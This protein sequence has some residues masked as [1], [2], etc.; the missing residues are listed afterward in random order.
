MPTLFSTWASCDGIDLL[1]ACG[2][3]ATVPATCPLCRFR[4]RS[5]KGNGGVDECCTLGLG[6]EMTGQKGNGENEPSKI[7]GERAGSRRLAAARVSAICWRSRPPDTLERVKR[8]WPFA[9]SGSLIRRHAHG[10]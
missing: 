6:K 5:T 1:G 10:N 9:L 3:A 7:L 2:Q 4:K 8:V